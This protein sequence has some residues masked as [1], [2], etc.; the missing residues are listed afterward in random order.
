[1]LLQV[2]PEGQ[3]MQ[4]SGVPH[5]YAGN[6]CSQKSERSNWSEYD[7]LPT[8]LAKQDELCTQTPKGEQLLSAESHP[9]SLYSAL[10]TIANLH[11]NSNSAESPS[12]TFFVLLE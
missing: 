3:A 9:L 2:R 12:E 8:E 5:S 10:L 11:M 1:M 7:P 6:K 4:E